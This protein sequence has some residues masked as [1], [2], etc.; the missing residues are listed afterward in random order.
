MALLIAIV[1]GLAPAQ[2]GARAGWHV[3]HNRV[4][5]CPG[6]SRARCEQVAELRSATLP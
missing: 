4:H 5:A 1:A 6:V 3:G 2:F